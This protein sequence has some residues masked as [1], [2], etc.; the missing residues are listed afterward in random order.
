MA[1]TVD[2][3]Q[4]MRNVRFYTE[5]PEHTNK[6]VVPQIFYRLFRYAM[7]WYHIVFLQCLR[8]SYV[9]NAIRI[10]T[11][12]TYLRDLV[13]QTVSISR[14]FGV[15][16]TTRKKGL[17]IFHVTDDISRAKITRD[18]RTY[19]FMSWTS[20]SRKTSDHAVWTMMPR[21][22]IMSSQQRIQFARTRRPACSLL[23][24]YAC[25]QYNE[26]LL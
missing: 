17:F 19:R 13:I 3:R 9:M 18:T 5:F 6:L 23:N 24:R 1:T 11:L 15:I 4:N 16:Y 10:F 7:R 14:T 2:K 22:R 12:G 26:L 25:K 8:V 20:V 21:E